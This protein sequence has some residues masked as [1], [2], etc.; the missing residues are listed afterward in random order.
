MAIHVTGF[1]TV[2]GFVA[3]PTPPGVPSRVDGMCSE[4]KAVRCASA[5]VVLRSEV[6]S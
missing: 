1:G 4:A 5:I 3:E 2:V 6:R